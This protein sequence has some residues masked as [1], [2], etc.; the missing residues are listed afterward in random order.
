MT[1][2]HDKTTFTKVIDFVANI[3]TNNPIYKSIFRTGYPST[4]LKRMAVMRSSFYM[5]ILPTKVGTH[6]LKLSYGWCMG[7]ITFFLFILLTIT[8]VLLMFYYIPSE[9]RAYQDMKD[10]RFMVPFGII[11]RNMHRWAAHGMVLSVMIHMMRVFYTGAY[12]PPRQF[13]WVIGVFLLL[14][15]LLLSFT[16][17]LLPWDQLGFWAV[18]VGTNMAASTPVLG[19]EGPFQ[20]LLGVQVDNDIRFAIIGGTRIGAN[21]LVRAYVWH[22][23][24]IPLIAALLMGFHFWRV[25]KDGFSGPL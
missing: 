4:I 24:G 6:G 16:G 17:Y 21:A 19:Y 5:H 11:L 12:K 1:E 9:N 22:V 25:R 20:Q 2:K 23:V 10:L 15:T 3:V 13:N 8:G 18:T 7:G 14:C